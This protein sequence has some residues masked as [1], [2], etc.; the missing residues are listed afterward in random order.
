[1]E[2]LL[3][4]IEFDQEKI[5][6]KANGIA[7][8]I[9]ELKTSNKQYTLFLYDFSF[10]G[11]D[12]VWC[13][14]YLDDVK[15]HHDRVIIQDLHIDSSM[16]LY[17]QEEKVIN[18]LKKALKVNEKKTPHY[19]EFDTL[20]M[21]LKWDGHDL[22]EIHNVWKTKLSGVYWHFIEIGNIYGAPNIN[23][24]TV[25][26]DYSREVNK[27]IIDIIRNAKLFTLRQILKP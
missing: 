10:G 24:I 14:P 2:R 15:D 25:N 8:K 19:A 5:E 11:S 12:E 17:E 13:R 6:N 27:P 21:G 18:T 16:P 1:M 4:S 7:K 20:G 26:E 23:A 3:D 22:Y 9:S